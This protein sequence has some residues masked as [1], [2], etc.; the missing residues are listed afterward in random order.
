[1]TRAKFR[2]QSIR[3]EQGTQW[4]EGNP[5]PREVQTIELYPVTGGSEENK[6]FYAS[7]PSG[8]IEL[9]VVNAEAAKLFELNKDH[10][11]DFSPAEVP[12][13]S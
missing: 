9:G 4:I 5:V 12:A 3:R 13:A 8:K 7:T 11:V 6:Q 1:M 10:Y 2:V